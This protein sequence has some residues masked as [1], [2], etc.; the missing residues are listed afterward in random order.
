[1]K[2]AAVL[3]FLL[4]MFLFTVGSANALPLTEEYTGLVALT[5]GTSAGFT[6]NF[7][8]VGNGGSPIPVGTSFTD[9]SG[10]AAPASFSWATVSVTF[11]DAIDSDTERRKVTLWLSNPDAQILIADL[12]LEIG[13]G[14]VF[15]HELT[16]TQL[17]N[18]NVFP[19]SS[20]LIQ[21]PNLAGNDFNVTRVAMRA[22]ST[23]VPEPSTMI[24]LGV[25]L[26]GLAGFGRNR[27]FKKA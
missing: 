13:S 21:A 20:L 1:M 23:P 24:L 19:K 3:L 4:L 25:G 26:I 6:F 9:V 22:G 27:F 14:S 2:K 15:N 17:A 5:G 8:A 16:P 10:V 11:T 7:V 18:F 12:T